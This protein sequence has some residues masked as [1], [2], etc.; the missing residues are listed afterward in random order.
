[1]KLPC[2]VVRDLLPLY[3]EKMTEPETQALVEAHLGDCPECRRRLSEIDATETVAP[4]EA[5]VPLKALKQEI[6]KRRWMTA[7]AAALIVFVA[8]YT[9][10]Y[11]AGEMRLLP[12]EDGLI[13]VKG[14]ET[15]PCEGL[16]E[17]GSRVV[18]AD[19]LPERSQE[20][21][22]DVLVLDVDARINATE[23][24][25]FTEDDGTSTV[26]LQGW[27][28]DRRGRG[29]RGEYDEM[30]FY[31]VPDRLIYSD[32]SRQTLLWGEPADG[33]VEVLPRLAL[34]YYVLLAAA[35]AAALGLLWL[36]FRNRDKKGMLRQL[37][38]APAS[39]VIAHLLIKGFR[40]TSYFMEQ[41]LLS[42]VLIAAALY[43][44]LTLLWQAWLRRRRE[45]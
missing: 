33:G 34:A 36:L 11:R 35:A 9:C 2:A 31:P 5:I 40:T 4:V 16:Y 3:A 10:F 41:D 8:V 42:I 14:V 39:Y 23:A 13:E 22:A 18:V 26:I 43:I 6:L 37:F 32:G 38:F 19:G 1:M 44:L 21:V 29:G 25:V 15:R 28:S 12:W 24:S 7:V 27:S 20:A 30:I 45:A 17:H